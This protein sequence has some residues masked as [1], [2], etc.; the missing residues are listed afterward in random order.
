MTAKIV[1]KGKGEITFPNSGIQLK[2]QGLI[3]A[4]FD[5]HYRIV[6]EFFSEDIA[7]YS[8]EPCA[9]DL[10]RVRPQLLSASQLG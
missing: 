4:V 3:V 2:N 9:S 6:A 7:T 8:E 1:L 5:K 10:C